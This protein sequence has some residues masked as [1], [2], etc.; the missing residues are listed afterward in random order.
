MGMYKLSNVDIVYSDLTYK[1]QEII[2]NKQSP[3]DVRRLL[4]EL[5]STALRMTSSMR[6]T[7]E[8]GFKLNSGEFND[9]NMISEIFKKLR[10][11]DHHENILK[12]ELDEHYIFKIDNADIHAT[13]KRVVDPLSVV[14]PQEGLEIYTTD[15]QTGA[16]TEHKAYTIKQLNQ[17]YILAVNGN[18]DYGRAINKLLEEVEK[19]DLF[20]L[21]EDYMNTL[22]KFYSF[23]L[24][25]RSQQNR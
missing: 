6:Q 23:Y 4:G 9:W 14:L 3:S 25:K 22:N 7:D 10:N 21:L 13:C 1:Y 5:V 19:N 8:M 18:S 17:K 15:P 2:K 20:Y 16:I 12:L 24:E 11:Y